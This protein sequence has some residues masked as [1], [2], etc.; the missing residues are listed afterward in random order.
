MYLHTECKAVAMTLGEVLF[1][2]GFWK[3]NHFVTREMNRTW[4]FTLLP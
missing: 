1:V 3:I 4:H 2:T